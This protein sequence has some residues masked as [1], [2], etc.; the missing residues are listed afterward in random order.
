[1]NMPPIKIS[2]QKVECSLEDEQQILDEIFDVLFSFILK[3][4]KATQFEIVKGL[5]I[6]SV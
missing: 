1:M 3:N 6:T 5:T 2:Y 4:D